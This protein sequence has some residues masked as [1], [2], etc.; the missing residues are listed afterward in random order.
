[1]LTFG[2]GRLHVAVLPAPSSVSV[3]TGSTSRLQPGQPNDVRSSGSGIEPLATVLDRPAIIRPTLTGRLLTLSVS[4][5]P[6]AGN[7]VQVSAGTP[8]VP[9]QPVPNDV[10]SAP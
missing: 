3:T 6:S 2:I 4:V 9:A 8:S 1:M 5:A 10:N 7:D